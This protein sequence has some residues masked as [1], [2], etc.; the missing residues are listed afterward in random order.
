[1]PE[2]EKAEE[3]SLP[4]FE[5]AELQDFSLKIFSKAQNLDLAKFMLI[6]SVA[7]NDFKD[8]M[9]IK[10]WCDDSLKKL[11][12]SKKTGALGQLYGLGEHCSRMLS[13]NFLELLITIKDH[14]NLFNGTEFDTIMTYLSKVKTDLPDL[15]RGLVELADCDSAEE[16]FYKC[17][18]KI[19]NNG[20]YHY[21]NTTCMYQ[22]LQ[23]Y[24]EKEDGVGYISMGDTLEKTR[25][26][27]GDA[28]IQYYHRKT[29]DEF[30]AGFAVTFNE[31]MRDINVLLRFMVEGY[32]KEILKVV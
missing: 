6:L 14:K 11:D 20:T 19:R 21:K 2:K 9:W 7:Y 30:G 15:W 12:T 29:T 13:A 31:Y 27:F 32:L 3:C 4:N 5:L 8:Y 25:F 24:I 10:Q 17:L 28:V 26:Y 23:Y 1:M 22:G 16:K 18:I